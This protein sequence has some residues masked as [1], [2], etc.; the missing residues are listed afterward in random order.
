MQ[1]VETIFFG[2]FH[3]SFLVNGQ[4]VVKE[5]DIRQRTFGLQPSHGT[6]TLDLCLTLAGSMGPGGRWHRSYGTYGTAN[7][8]MG[9]LRIWDLA[10]AQSQTES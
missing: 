1:A 3:P 6:K 2:I 4:N 5:G 8:T 7:R 10:V 9:R